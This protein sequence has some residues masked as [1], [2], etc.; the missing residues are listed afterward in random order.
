MGVDEAVFAEADCE[1]GADLLVWGEDG[2]GEG[3]T[4]ARFAGAAVAYAD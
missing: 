3:K 4:N 1:L 2:D